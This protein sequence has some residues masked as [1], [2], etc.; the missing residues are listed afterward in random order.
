VF[1]EPPAIPPPV[2]VVE[3]IV[4]SAPAAPKT[5]FAPADPGLGFTGGHIPQAES[6]DKAVVPAEFVAPPVAAPVPPAAPP[7]AAVVPVE[8]IISAAAGEPGTKEI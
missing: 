8:R 1:T 2:F 5:E 6:L 4:K 3:N 7:P